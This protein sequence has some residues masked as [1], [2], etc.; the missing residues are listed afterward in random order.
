MNALHK[1]YITLMQEIRQIQAKL[2]QAL[3]QRGVTVGED[4]HE[5]FKHIVDQEE[6]PFVT[7]NYQEHSFARIFWESQIVLTYLTQR[8]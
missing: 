1:K 6:S 5:N 7:G 3:E 2:D 4:L 8:V